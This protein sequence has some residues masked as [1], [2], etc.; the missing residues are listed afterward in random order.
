M[1]V[2]WMA[3]TAVAQA[4][5]CCAVAGAVTPAVLQPGERVGIAVGT[6][7]S[8][9]IG[10]W[11]SS[12][13]FLGTEQLARD[14]ARVDG[15]VMVRVAQPLQL[16]V[17][18]RVRVERVALPGVPSVVDDVV[19]ERSAAVRWTPA[20]SGDVRPVAQAGW[21]LGLLGRSTT[22]A[23]LSVEARRRRGSWA[24]G[25]GV[26][27]D[28]DAVRVDMRGTVG[29][30]LGDGA[31]ILLA[32]RLSCERARTGVSILPELA[33]SVPVTMGSH[34][35]L[36]PSVALAPPVA[37]LGRRAPAWVT[38]GLGAVATHG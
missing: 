17:G 30:I 20:V 8:R 15:R 11:S 5:S 37:G 31:D 33:V 35:R 27:R 21:G 4:A 32:G 23:D 28:V 2:A 38:V 26:V 36:V 14:A 16:L 1:L 19:E 6:A 18:G 9:W 25:A 34:L 29:W 10:D 22:R 24:A 7:G 13:A 12:G 3:W